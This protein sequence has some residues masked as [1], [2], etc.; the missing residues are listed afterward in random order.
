[1]VF[2]GR[3]G[4]A[5]LRC[6]FEEKLGAQLWAV[7]SVESLQLH[8][9]DQLQR[10]T[11]PSSCPS[12][13]QPTSGN[14]AWQRHNGQPFSLTRDPQTGKACSRVHC[15]VRLC[16]RSQWHISQ[17]RSPLLSNPTS[18]FFPSQVITDC[19]GGNPT[20][21]P[22]LMVHEED[23][24]D[25]PYSHSH[26]YDLSQGEDTK[27]NQH[28]EKAHGVKSWRNPE[29]S[30]RAVT[31]DLFSSSS[32][33]CNNTAKLMRDSVPRAFLFFFLMTWYFILWYKYWWCYH[34]CLT[35]PNFFF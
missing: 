14:R 13:R 5:A 11:S 34:C 1:M 29:S 26:S 24:Q 35:S 17:L 15:Q 21:T 28:R 33:R 9:L 22:S 12:W 10:V 19:A 31:Q 20:T 18:T 32:N 4:N 8:G 2:K 23:S 16:H 30:L 27:Q 25:P 7:W 6:P 3:Q